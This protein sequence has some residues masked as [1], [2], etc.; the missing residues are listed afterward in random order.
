MVTGDNKD[1]ARAIAKDCGI[2]TNDED[3]V[4][5]GIIIIIFLSLIYIFYLSQR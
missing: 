1:T 3:I 4:I 2:V 5:E